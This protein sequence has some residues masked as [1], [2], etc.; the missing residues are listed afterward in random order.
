MQ[1]VILKVV[2]CHLTL[3]GY[4]NRSDIVSM[5]N[6][7]TASVSRAIKHYKGNCSYVSENKRYETN[8][9]FI[10]QYPQLE[11]LRYLRA[12]QIVFDSEKTGDLQ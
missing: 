5:C 7:G 11:H 4:F 10:S 6:V 1:D 8:S 12:C 3:Y 2:D 9:G